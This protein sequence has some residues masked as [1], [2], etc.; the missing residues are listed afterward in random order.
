MW[1]GVR[2][3]LYCNT[4]KAKVQP[5]ALMMMMMIIII[6]GNAGEG[7]CWCVLYLKTPKKK[8]ITRSKIVSKRKEKNNKK[9]MYPKTNLKQMERKRKRKKWVLTRTQVHK[10]ENLTQ[11]KS[12]LR[13]KITHINRIDAPDVY[14][15]LHYVQRIEYIRSNGLLYTVPNPSIH[16]THRYDCTL[17]HSSAFLFEVFVMVF[18]PA[19][20]SSSF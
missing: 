11:K 9:K 2:W 5:N 7:C 8:K 18:F 20:F 14:N 13:S 6:V 3:I 15:Y 12:T 10:Y 1:T 19:F 4:A 16:H 17:K